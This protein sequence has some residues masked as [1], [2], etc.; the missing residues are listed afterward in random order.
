MSGDDVILAAVTGAHGITGEVRLK[1]FADSLASLK[2]HKVFSAG[3]QTLT[4]KAIRPGGGGK[5]VGAVAR[6][7]EIA[8][9]TAA[10]GLRGT[11]LA[12]PRASLPPLAEGEYYHADYLGRAVVDPDGEP[13]GTV[14]AIENYGASDILDIDLGE[15]RTVM[16]P[17]IPTAV[18]EAE[19]RLIVDRA[20][21]G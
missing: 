10:E 11:T 2:A 20:W 14:R 19:G 17:F 5:G 1:L 7:A 9:R 12:V 8:D 15:G 16:V 3:G 21:L 6:F 4:L 18:T 13:I